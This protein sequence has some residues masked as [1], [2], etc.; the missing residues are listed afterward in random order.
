LSVVA[1]QLTTISALRERVAAFVQ[2][3]AWEK[4]HNPKDLAIAIAIEAGELM[5]LYLWK[6]AHEVE[7]AQHLAEVQMRVEE[8]LADI[9]IL[10]LSFANRLGI[11][12][13]DAVVTK[14]ARNEAKYPADV[15]RGNAHK[16]THY[17]ENL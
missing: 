11:D 9:V 3:R 15:V 1:D 4:F 6:D 17:E 12:V 5:E 14:V 2:A 10:C 7:E 8:E 16:Y 13:S